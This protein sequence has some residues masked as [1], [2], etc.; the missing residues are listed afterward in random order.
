MKKYTDFQEMF[1]DDDYITP[2]ER[3]RV[4]KEVQKMK[5]Q[6]EEYECTS[7]DNRE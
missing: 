3:K 6:M 2:E 1:N 5:C 4:E 7:K